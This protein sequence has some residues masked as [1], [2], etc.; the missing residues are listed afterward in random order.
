MN[1]RRHDAIG[2]Y[3]DNSLGRLKLQKIILLTLLYPIYKERKPARRLF[4]RIKQH[5]LYN[6][7]EII[8]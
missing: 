1:M 8:S 2:K 6:A 4:E 5:C 3:L 7:F